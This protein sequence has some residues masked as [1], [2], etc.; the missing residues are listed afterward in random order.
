[1][2]GLDMSKLVA[3]YRG[4][5]IPMIETPDPKIIQTTSFQHANAQCRLDTYFQASLCSVDPKENVSDE[6]PTVGVCSR[7]I[8]GEVGSR[9]LCWFAP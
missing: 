9:P 4:E 6:D 5:A 7:V 8:Q 3:D 1:M 2:A